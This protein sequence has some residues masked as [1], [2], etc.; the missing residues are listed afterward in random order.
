MWVRIL[1]SP[2]NLME[3]DGPLDGKKIIII[4]QKRQPNGAS[5]KLK[6]I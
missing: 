6:K 4:K 1:A 5:H 3:K 2:K